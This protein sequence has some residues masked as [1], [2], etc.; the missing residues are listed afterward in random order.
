M[1]SVLYKEVIIIDD[2][3]Y[4]ELVCD[5]TESVQAAINADVLADDPAQIFDWVVDDV[6]NN[7]DRT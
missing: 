4:A 2:K 7:M 3:E 6:V 1:K 5:Y